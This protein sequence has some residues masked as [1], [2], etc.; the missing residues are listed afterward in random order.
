MNTHY[1]IA[2][3]HFVYRVAGWL[4]V[5]VGCLLIL[6]SAR[7]E[8]VGTQ[9]TYQGRLQDAGQPANGLF[10]LRFQL[11]D[12]P[13]GN[14]AYT[15]GELTL[16]DVPVEDG[17]FSVV[18]DFGAM[19]FAGD[20]RWL[21]IQVRDGDSNGAF[22]LLSPRQALTAT[23]YALY[24]LEG[25]PGP[26]GPAG[27]SGVVSTYTF[28]GTINNIQAGGGGA[29][30]VFAGPTTTVTVAD[31]QRIT[32]AGTAAVGHFS[33]T[34]TVTVS[35]S[36]CWSLVPAGS[37]LEA[38]YPTQ[39]PDTSVPLAPQKALLAAAATVSLAAGSYRVG[40]CIKNKSNTTTLG[41]SDVVSGWVMVTN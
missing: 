36:L 39:Y 34:N 27:Q 9:F 12:V 3:P 26:Q 37:P 5:V 31:G 15:S 10:D 18:L 11:H 16:E 28:A 6:D 1:F 19:A 41:A 23:P 40:F 14:G 13:N 25:N 24:A 30:W 33:T 22:D 35:A 38:F 17:V 8:A 2:N 7:A 21:S 20:A 29:P 32:G 4:L